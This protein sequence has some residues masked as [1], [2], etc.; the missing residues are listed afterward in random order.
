MLLM[1]LSWKCNL[2]SCKRMADRGHKYVGEE[3]GVNLH[4]KKGKTL[5]DPSVGKL[6]YLAGF[7]SPLN[8]SN[9]TL[10]TIAP[11]NIMCF[12]PVHIN[13]FHTSHGHVHEKLL[14]STAK[15][16][17]SVLKGF[18]RECEG[19]SVATCLGK[20]IDITSST[21]ADKVFG[22]L[23]VDICEKWSGA[24]I[25]GKRYMLLIYDDFSRFTWTYFMRQKLDNFV[26]FCSFGRRTRG[27]KP[28]SSRSGMSG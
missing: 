20:P 10:A 11:G 1:F 13:T 27:R 22:R 7:R 9:F 23:F 3:K 6:N 28:L 19:C 12:S 24:S 2:L 16:L 26:A 15:Q 17:G 14:R 25:G 5:F 21:K 4:L 18:L 8:S